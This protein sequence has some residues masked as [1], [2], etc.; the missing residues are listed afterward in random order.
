MQALRLYGPRDLRLVEEP[1][2]VPA[3]GQVL[4][5]VRSVT[6]CHSDIH[7]YHDGHIGDTHATVPLVLGHE[8]SAEVV[9]VPEGVTHIKPGDL[10]AVEPA[11]SCGHC[12]ACIEGNPNIC[13]YLQFSGTPPLDGALREYMS[14]RPEFCFALPK[15]MTADE[16]ALLEPLGVALYAW[17]LG[18]LRVAETVA[19]VGCGPIGLLAVQ[20]ARIAG[21]SQILAVE[22]LAYRRELAE[23]WGAIALD[24]ADD[25]EA[26]VKT[27]THG[28]G[29][30]LVIEMAGALPAQDTASRLARRGGKV[31]LVGI[32][33][34]DQILMSHH[35]PRRKDLNIHVVRRMK[36]TYPRAIKLVQQKMIAVMPLATHHFRLDQ[37]SE[38]FE[39]VSEYRD[40]VL[41]AVITP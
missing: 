32:P 27:L 3:P 19:I 24:P 29:V 23:R 13:E 15:D 2:P 16:G 12:W 36:H 25:L 17:D 4:L 38:A 37:A 9:S 41:K 18:R 30:D 35:V 21:A 7:Y 6:V 26:R 40:G 5:R 28:R 31:L 39:L 11:V 10:V 33:P 34:E 22:P 8:F 20:L 1:T 14:Y